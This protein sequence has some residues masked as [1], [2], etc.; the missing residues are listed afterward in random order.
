MIASLL[1]IVIPAETEQ[2]ISKQMGITDQAALDSAYQAYAK[3]YVNRSVDVPAAAVQDSI[4]YARSQGT[5][6]VRPN[7][8]DLIDTRFSRDLQSSGFL[9]RLWGR[10]IPASR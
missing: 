6:V 8:A 1:R 9:E 7:A 4:D 5:N 2:S 3:D 10:P